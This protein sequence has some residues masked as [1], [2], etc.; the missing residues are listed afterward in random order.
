IVAHGVALKPGKPVCL[1]VTDGK[2]VVVLPGFPT[3]AIFTFHEFMA[4]VLRAFAGLP[5]EQHAQVPATLPM[6]INSERGRTEYLLVGLIPT[7]HGHVAYPMGKGSGSVTTFSAADGFIKID[8]HTEMLDAGA[9]AQVQ[10]IDRHTSAADLVIMGSHCLGLDWLIQTLTSQGLRIKTMNIGSTGGLLAAKRGEC[11]VAGIHLLDPHTN[12]YNAPLLSPGL[13]LIPGYGRMQGIVFRKDDV[14]FAASDM[15]SA[16]S[17][18]VSDARCSMVNRNPG[19][20]TRILLD[21]LLGA[22]RPSGY[23]LQTKSHN[24][25][26]VA[27]AQKRADWGMA[28]DTVAAQYGLGF[29]PVQQEEYDFVIPEQRLR[30]EAVQLFVQTLQS[31]RAQEAFQQL[32]FRSKISCA[33]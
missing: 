26:A 17:V 31:E 12:T 20:G 13:Q 25:V 11:D 33:A 30:R 15:A 5:T 14:R 22:H 28:I 10:L 6:R 16:L 7:E 27:V 24:A 32:G 23:G 8:Q 2:P 1:A 4:P 29:I 21:Q 19:S 18:I 3:S 9:M